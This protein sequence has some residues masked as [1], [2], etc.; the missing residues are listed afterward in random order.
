M[1]KVNLT[2]EKYTELIETINQQKE[3]I[4][5][6]E[7]IINEEV[8]SKG[9]IIKL[10]GVVYTSDEIIIN[11]EKHIKKLQ[12]EIKRYKEESAKNFWGRLFKT[13]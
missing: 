4:I 13:K 11:K 8:R 3:T 10:D 5:A 7:T 6:L 1:N 9:Y 12:D 2:L